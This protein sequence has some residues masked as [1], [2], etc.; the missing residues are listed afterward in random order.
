MRSQDTVFVIGGVTGSVSGRELAWQFLKNNWGK[1]YERYEGG[2][3]L[4]RLVKSTT[5]NFISQD[6]CDDIQVLKY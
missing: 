1:L 6:K 3:L 5:E 2:F 4:A